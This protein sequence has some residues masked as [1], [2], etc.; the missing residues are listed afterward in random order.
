MLPHLFYALSLKAGGLS[1]YLPQPS[2]TQP[3]VPTLESPAP[4]FCVWLTFPQTCF[5]WKFCS[6][7]SGFKHKISWWANRPEAP[8]SAAWPTNNEQ[9]RWNVLSVYIPEKFVTQI[10]GTSQGHLL[11][12]HWPSLMNA[13]IVDTVPAMPRGRFLPHRLSSFSLFPF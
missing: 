13:S 9:W 11:H 5:I 4:P 10:I 7:A 1:M 3:S 6:V 12:Q 2:Q 8:K